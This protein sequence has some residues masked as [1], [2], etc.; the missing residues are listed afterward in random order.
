MTEGRGYVRREG[1]KWVVLLI[2][3]ILAADR[4][5]KRA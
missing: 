2:A 3:L 5:G 4:E 1:E